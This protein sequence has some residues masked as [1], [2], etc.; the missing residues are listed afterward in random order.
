LAL[1]RAIAATS[2][3]EGESMVNF[4]LMGTLMREKKRMG[5]ELQV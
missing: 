2:K 5:Q 3:K 4:I 1:Q